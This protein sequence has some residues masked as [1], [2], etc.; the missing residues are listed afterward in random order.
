MSLRNPWPLS[1]VTGFLGSGKTTLITN[2]LRHAD[3][4]DTAVIVNE[5]G[6][7]GLDHHLIRQ[8]TD[9]V[10]LLPN[11]CLCCTV[12]QDIVQ[13]LRELHGAWLAGDIP[14]FRR[15]LVE[16]TGLAEPEPLVAS[17]AGHPLLADVFALTAVVT[18]VDAEH[19]ARQL[20]AHSTS[21]RQAMLADHLVVSK[22][23][24][25]GSEQIALL[26]ADLVSINPLASLRQVPA[27]TSPDFLFERAAE[28]PA[29]SS[30]ICVPEAGH[31]EQFNTRVLKPEGPLSWRLFQLWLGNLLDRVGPDLL[32]LKG[33]L[34]FDQAP[35]RVII[36][37]VHQTFYP[38]T[39][40]PGA[41]E[42]GSEFLVLIFAGPPPADLELGFAQCLA[43]ECNRS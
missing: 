9:Q 42:D 21:W 5:F 43:K 4:V 15:V 2:L 14:D 35:K 26:R 7:I 32:R 33:C 28:R 17:L 25:V 29:R 16:T 37:A 13:T 8:V 41:M 10:K 38:V 1:I 31:V 18:V 22:C 27:P 40:A 34:L 6:E 19:G 3:M 30:F 24:R 36:Q 20:A 39:E 12:R 23:D 11:G